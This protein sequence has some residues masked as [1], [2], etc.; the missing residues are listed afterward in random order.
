MSIA[1]SVVRRLPRW[2]FRDVV[3]RSAVSLRGEG[4]VFRR[5][6]EL[7]GLQYEDPSALIDRQRTHAL[8]ML[9]YARE[10]SAWYRDRLDA[11]AADASLDSLLRAPLLSKADL[12]VHAALLRAFPQPPRISAKTTGGS[13]GRAVTVL[14]DRPSV[15]GE[16]AATWLGYGW[17]GIEPGDR[18]AR[19]WGQP[20]HLRRRIRFAAADLAMN[21][22]RFSAFAFSEADLD[23]YWRA[24]LAFRPR[25]LYG[26]VSMLEAFARFVLATRRD[27]RGLGLVSVVTTSEALSEQQRQV[28]GEAFG[29]PVQNE[30]GC[31]EVGPVAYECPQGLLHIMT[32]NVLV[33]VVRPDG[34]HA[35]PGE[36]GE[37]VVTDLMNRA[38][39]LI[40]YQ[41]GDYATLGGECNCGRG[42]P[43]LSKVWGRA[44]D[45]V[46]SAD[47]RRYHGEFFLYLIE[48][49]RERGMEIHQFK[50]RQTTQDAL[51]VLV[52]APQD[53]DGV[54]AALGSGLA[55]R[56]PGF[57]VAV[58]QVQEIARAASGKMQLIENC[59]PK[60]AGEAPGLSREAS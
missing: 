60:P 41:L 42:F 28:I 51:E 34:S 11:V 3:Y 40:R 38:M 32:E 17:F 33:E 7:E 23:R 27:G 20:A 16:M 12:Q 4:D 47:G 50:V 45:F 55:S 8:R 46:E 59:L 24:C 43:T 26:Y 30:Y 21:R 39:P 36:S 25:Y 13:T 35:G 58:L 37:V 54:A 48:E 2:F 31:G 19:F 5:L 22:I 6:H 56:L 10:H 9:R 18:A 44:Y 57:S 49:L 15:A 14:K 52:V 29:A 53:P 1:L